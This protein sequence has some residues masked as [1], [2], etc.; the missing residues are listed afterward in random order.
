MD[1]EEIYKTLERGYILSRIELK[2]DDLEFYIESAIVK[3]KFNIYCMKLENGF[4][5][6]IDSSD[7]KYNIICDTK[8]IKS[9]WNKL[10]KKEQ[11]SFKKNMSEK[12]K[13]NRMYKSSM[14][15]NTKRFVN[16]LKKLE[17]AGHQI[18]RI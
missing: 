9:F 16:H 1:Y 5:K 18:E 13:E 2:I 7:E 11:R 8:I 3:S 15:S 4:I 10:S 12:E 17:K 6:Y 14:W